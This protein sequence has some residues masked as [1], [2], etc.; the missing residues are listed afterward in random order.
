MISSIEIET[1]FYFL[2]FAVTTGNYENA[3]LYLDILRKEYENSEPNFE[4]LY[5][6]DRMGKLSE[7]GKIVDE[8]K[9]QKK[10]DIK[11][12][13]G[14]I[15]V[16]KDENR[17]KKE[18]HLSKFLCQKQDE[19]K[20]ILHGTE[21]FNIETER[22]KVTFGE[23]DL[24]ARDKDVVYIIELKR[25]EVKHDVIGQID[26]Y[27]YDF[28]LK[29]IYKLWKEVIGVVVANSYNKYALNELKKQNI[30]CLKYSYKN[31]NLKLKRL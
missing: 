28:R 26:K 5:Q 17:F 24:V 4:I 1:L 11:S 27:M 22:Q 21:K 19:L 18:K 13:K 30:I 3:K 16:E 14:N 23:V 7:L 31:K 8:G 12:I 9:L 2:D 6:D 20:K 29:M 25:E 10:F 15:I